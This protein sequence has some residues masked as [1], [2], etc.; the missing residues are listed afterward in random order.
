MKKRQFFQNAAIMTATSLLLRLIGIVFRIYISNRVGAEGMGLYQ[1]I[2]SVYVLAASFATAGL[3]TAVTRL[4]ADEMV[5]GSAHSVKR[6]VNICIIMSVVIGLVSAA[7]IIIGA[8]AIAGLFINDSRAVPALKILTLSLPFMGISS[9]LRGYFAARRRITGSSFSQIL[10]QVVRIAAI[11]V[12]LNHMPVITA[13]KACFAI[14]L[15]DTIAEG[16]SCFF[17]CAIYHID[18]RRLTNTTGIGS[19]TSTLIKQ[20]AH[21]ALPITSGRYLN[22]VLRTIENTLVPRAL[23]HF[24]HSHSL[25]LAQFGKLKG[26]AMPLIFF[27]SSFLNAFSVLLIPEV[28]EAKTLREHRQLTYTIGRAFHMT[29]LSSFLIAGIFWILAYPIGELIYHDPEVGNMIRIL[30][31]LTPVMYLESVVVGILK[32]LD[33]Q[34]HS[35]V[36]SVLDSVTRIGMIAAFTPT[37][38][39]NG[40]FVVMIIS[41]LLTCALNTNRLCRV[42]GFHIQYGKWIIRPTAAIMIAVCAASQIPCPVDDNATVCLIHGGVTC[43]VYVILLPLLSCVDKQDLLTFKPVIKKQSRC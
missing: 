38:G 14:L 25:S 30:S 22:S 27:P 41:N 17:L 39:L 8:D 11:G 16:V 40:F 43:L 32:G 24:T 21:I 29:L 35:L 6:V 33:Q 12:M 15:G 7:V 34:S 1:L 2:I 13:E 19:D 28:S 9:C 4:C 18:K 23:N 10:E 31:A 37:Y 36:Y 5:R 26:M 42:T 3:C 20:T